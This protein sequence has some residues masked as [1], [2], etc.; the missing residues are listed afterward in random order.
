MCRIVKL[1]YVKHSQLRFVFLASPK[2]ALE[3]L[4]S[5]IKNLCVKHI[6]FYSFTFRSQSFLGLVEMDWPGLPVFYFP[7]KC[8]AVIKISANLYLKF[9]L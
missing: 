6:L 7:V 1:V 2:P 8:D 5:L 3:F 4:S 9:A